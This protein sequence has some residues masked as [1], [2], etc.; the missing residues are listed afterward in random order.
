MKT[1]TMLN[2]RRQADAIVRQVAQGERMVLTY[3]GKPMIRL[4]PYNE[5]TPGPEDPFYALGEAA[6]A[7]GQTLTNADMDRIIYADRNVR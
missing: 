6:A 7:D 2:L 1:V 3:R 4:E 5:S